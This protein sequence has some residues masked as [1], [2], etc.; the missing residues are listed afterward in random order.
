[1]N[2]IKQNP[3]KKRQMCFQESDKTL[4]GMGVK[5]TPV[6]FAKIPYSFNNNKMK[7]EKAMTEFNIIQFLQLRKSGKTTTNARKKRKTV[8]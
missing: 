4:L 2:V 7:S 3:V 1:M 5:R 8:R 6:I